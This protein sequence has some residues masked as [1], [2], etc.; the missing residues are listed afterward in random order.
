VQH[1]A[2]DHAALMDA[3]YRHQRHIYDLT[4]ACYLLGRDGLIAEIAPPPAARVLEIACG[5][6]R[7]LALLGAR[8]PQARLYGL[9]ISAQMLRSAEDR[10]GGRARLA[11][12]DACTFD[13]MQTFGVPAFDAIVLSY[14]LSM[15]P[16]WTAALDHAFGCLAPGGKLHVVDFHDQAGLPGWFGWGLRAWLRRFHVTPRT[17][18]AQRGAEVAARYGAA[19]RHRIIGRGYAQTLVI[20][21]PALPEARTAAAI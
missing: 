9:D 11:R 16:D 15:I 8:H 14:A 6:G 2:R 18:L 7:N 5:T 19:C 3:I 12:A 21:A 17:D 13:P 20:H 4:R 10:L 1:P